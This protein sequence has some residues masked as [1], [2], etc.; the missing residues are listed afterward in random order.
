MTPYV[1]CMI[2]FIFIAKSLE[3]FIKEL[4][5]ECSNFVKKND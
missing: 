1:I 3:Y 4:L 2:F 5:L